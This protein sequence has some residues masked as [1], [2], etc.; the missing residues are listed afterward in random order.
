MGKWK[1][2]LSERR[3]D[4]RRKNKKGVGNGKMKTKTD[5][6]MG[7]GRIKKMLVTG[8][9]KQRLSERRSDGTTSNSLET[10]W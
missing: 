9:W 10:H 1:Q 7:E 6:V 8:K 5:E 2:R 3:S 4:R